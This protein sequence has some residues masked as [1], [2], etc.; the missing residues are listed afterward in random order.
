MVVVRPVKLEDLDR[1]MELAHIASFGL[2]SLPRDRDLLR[3][4]IV[5]SM[6]SFSK[7]TEKPAGDL[8]L[9]V[10]EDL[11]VGMV[12]GTSALFQ[13]WE[14]LNPFTRTEFKPPSISPKY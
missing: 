13:R 14:V 6:R 10:L 8:F 4:R 12:V 11:D 3:K 2:T 5:E 1:L 7:E 9:F